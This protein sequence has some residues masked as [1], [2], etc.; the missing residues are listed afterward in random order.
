M[1]CI[2]FETWQLLHLCKWRGRTCTQQPSLST[3]LLTRKPPHSSFIHC[4]RSIDFISPHRL[5][6]IIFPYCVIPGLDLV[7]TVF[8]A[9]L[10]SGIVLK[11]KH[12]ENQDQGTVWLEPTWCWLREHIQCDTC[13]NNKQCA[14]VSPH[15]E[16]FS[17]VSLMGVG[18]FL[19]VWGQAIPLTT[20]ARCPQ[21]T[22]KQG[23]VMDTGKKMAYIC[24]IAVEY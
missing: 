12:C 3:Q 9:A 4:L 17:F 11:W 2:F 1:L 14:V 8:M 20:L 19:P 6:S 18:M 10:S 5:I 24:D 13:D 21:R 7:A 23:T 22:W 16:L 15:F